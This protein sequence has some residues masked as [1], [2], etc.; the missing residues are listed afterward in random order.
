MRT[1]RHAGNTAWAASLARSISVTV[2]AATLPSE[3]L[4]VGVRLSKFGL[5]SGGPFTINKV[6]CG[7]ALEAVE[8]FMSQGQVVLVIKHFKRPLF[9]MGKD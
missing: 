2:P 4:S 3:V 7:V 8:I 6:S 1:L 9:N 5:V